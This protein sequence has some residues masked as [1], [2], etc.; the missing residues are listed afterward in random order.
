MCSAVIFLELCFIAHVAPEL[1]K[2]FDVDPSSVNRITLSQLRVCRIFLLGI[3]Q[4]CPH[5]ADFYVKSHFRD[6]LILN[7]PCDMFS[8]L[9]FSI[10]P[11]DDQCYFNLEKHEHCLGVISISSSEV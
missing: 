10:H 2:P 4:H 9:A 5:S 8:S 7:S 6:L 3:S 1:S 11:C